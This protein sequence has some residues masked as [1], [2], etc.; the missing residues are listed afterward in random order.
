M[1]GL[2]R[3]LAREA[4]FRTLFQIDVG[5][6]DPETSLSYNKVE[7]GL[8]SG[9][10]RFAAFLVNGV[11]ANREAIDGIIKK[12]AENWA[13]HRL[14]AT[15]RAV[16]RLAIFELT[17]PENGV[18]PGAVINEAVELAKT[19]GDEDSGRFVNGILSAVAKATPPVRADAASNR[20]EDSIERQ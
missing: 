17:S 5:K 3:R 2:S 13:L 16:L 1:V 15:D 19:Y 20:S 12:H 18:P 4:A 11:L 10:S 6:N 7:M 9:E 14:A 8:D